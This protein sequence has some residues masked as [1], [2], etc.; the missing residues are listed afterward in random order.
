MERQH[1]PARGGPGIHKAD[2]SGPSAKRKA[3]ECGVHDSHET[4]F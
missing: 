4:G 1:S 3:R 2:P